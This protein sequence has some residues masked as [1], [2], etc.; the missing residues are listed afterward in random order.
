ML[1]GP[2]RR[3]TV[4]LFLALVGCGESAA[5]TVADTDEKPTPP[6]PYSGSADLRVSCTPA[7][8]LGEPI[9]DPLPSVACPSGWAA[10]E[11]RSAMP[12]AGRFTTAREMIEAF[13]VLDEGSAT[14]EPASEIDFAKNDVIAIAYVGEIG[15]HRRAGELWIRHTEQCGD[16]RSHR[17]ALFA[18]PKSAE[19]REQ[20]CSD[21]CR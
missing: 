9:A 8:A 17:T 19:V 14:S 11:G 20:V 7:V 12:V 5:T 16:D 21:G 18:V 15:L 4:A 2:K 1:L 13:C 3:F 10:R 6:T